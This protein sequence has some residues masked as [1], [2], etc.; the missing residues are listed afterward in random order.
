MPLT[1]DTIRLMGSVQGL[2][3]SIVIFSNRKYKSNLYLSIFILLLSIHTVLISFYNPSMLNKYPWILICFDF[4]PF[5]YGPLIYFY[6]TSWLFKNYKIS[7]K[8]ILHF[9]PALV[10]I[11]FYGLLSFIAGYEY[12]KLSIHEYFFSGPQIYVLIFEWGKIA[13]GITYSILA[14]RLLIRHK[15]I[16][17][18]RFKAREHRFWLISLIWSFAFCWCI[19]LVSNYIHY[20]NDFKA[21]FLPVLHSFQIGSFLI[22]F[23][24][25]TFFNMRYPVI[26]NPKE[27]REQI[28]GRL[29]LSDNQ[30]AR[31]RAALE[32]QIN[33]KYY[34][35]EEVSLKKLSSIMGIHPNILS[36]LINE[37]Y[38]KNFTEFTNFLRLEYFLELFTHMDKTMN[39][40]LTLAYKAGFPSKSTFNRVFKIN[41]GVSPTEYKK[42][43]PISHTK[44]I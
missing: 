31:L 29:N 36:F 34:I 25:V 38:G 2:I 32:I 3:L 24:L 41:T 1:V 9:L 43:S 5:L 12:I 17:Q 22:F 37:E 33:D 44:A 28:K 13:S 26:L 19:V 40:I 8:N 20:I 7:I 15:S 18:R 10:D 11:I 42:N 39:S 21:E 23:Y 30:I 16:I 14:V 35:D 6:I 27:L 4:L